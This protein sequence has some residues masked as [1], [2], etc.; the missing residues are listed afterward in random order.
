M[1]ETSEAA[2]PPSALPG[3]FGLIDGAIARIEAFFLA[4]GVLLMALNVVANVVGRFAFG[5]SIQSA[6]EINR[7]L[8]ILI[9]FAGLS[10]AARQGR[11]IRMSAFYDRLPQRGRK[12]MMIF[13]SLVTA[14]I[15]FALSRYALQYMLTQQGRGRVLPSLQ[16]PVWL[17]LIWVPVGFFMAGL[18]YAL[19]AL[20]NLTAPGVHLSTSLAEAQLPD[21]ALNRGEPAP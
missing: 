4:A 14:A 9:T 3:I 17:M 10:Y 2:R 18:Q 15:M 6:E 8:I 7:I 11:H 13:I 5:R 20:R 19:T 16:I 21:P 12:I 1:S